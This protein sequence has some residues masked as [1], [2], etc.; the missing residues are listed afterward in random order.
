MSFRFQLRSASHDAHLLS[1]RLER[2]LAKSEGLL[3]CTRFDNLAVGRGSHPGGFG[4][5]HDAAMAEQYELL[6]GWVET[7]EEWQ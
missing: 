6:V 3:H 2:V 5:G 1:N 7:E 4:C